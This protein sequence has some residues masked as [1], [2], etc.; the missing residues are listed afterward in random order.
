MNSF[1]HA[2]EYDPIDE[3]YITVKLLGK[4]VMRPGKGVPDIR[5]SRSH[6]LRPCPLWLSSRQRGRLE[7]SQASQCVYQQY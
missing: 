4:L 2:V 7:V 1:V 6:F 3:P 5:S